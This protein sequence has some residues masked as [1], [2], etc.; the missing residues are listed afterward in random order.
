MLLTFPNGPGSTS[1]HGIAMT[2]FRVASNV[3]GHNSSKPHIRIQGT[4]GEIDVDGPAFRPTH[5]RF[6]PAGDESQPP[7]VQEH[8]CPIP[9]Q[10]MFWEADEA[11]RCV[12]DGKLES[13]SLTWEESVVIMETMD[14]VRKQHGLK[15]PE[16]IETLDYPVDL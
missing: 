3:D 8:D 4:K 14:E 13:E 16:K 1:A 7:N 10:G 5:Y 6:I 11:G 12:R 2:N 9:G 15:Y